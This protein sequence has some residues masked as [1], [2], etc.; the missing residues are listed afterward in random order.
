MR[1]HG[2][3]VAIA[4]SMLLV[5]CADKAVTSPEV[6]ATKSQRYELSRAP[7]VIMSGLNSPRQLAFGPEGGLYVAE[8]GTGAINGPCVAVARGQHCYSGTASISRWWKGTQERVATGLPSIGNPAINDIGGVNDIAFQGRG[9]MFVTSGWGANPALRAG[10]GAFGDDLGSL[11]RVTPNGAWRAVADVSAFEQANNPAGGPVDSNPYGVLAEGNDRYVTDAGGNSLLHV[12]VHGEVS[13]VAVFPSTVVPPLP[14]PFPGRTSE[15]VPTEVTRGPDG[16]LYVSTLSGVPFTPGV[17]RIYRVVPGSAPTVHVDGLTQVTNHAWGPDGSLYVT[18]FGT[19]FFFG[20]PGSV[21]RIAP[22]GVRS[23]V[24]G[25]LAGP[26]G[27][28][29]GPDGA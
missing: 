4:G 20:G 9:N 10:L 14:F 11:L 15:A 6:M 3:L 8:A 1:H 13:L 22:N 17:A 12:D 5:A 24:I 7:M 26:T 25:G 27:V 23:T 29:V 16:A 28:E 18:Q 2:R 19:A 21:L